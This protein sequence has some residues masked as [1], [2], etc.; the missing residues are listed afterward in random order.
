MT[1]DNSGNLDKQALQKSFD[2]A[3]NHEGRLSYVEATVKGLEK[4]MN[5]L[6]S[7]MKEAASTFR[8]EIEGVREDFA[9]FRTELAEFRA[10]LAESRPWWHT[11][12]FVGVIIASNVVTGVTI[13]L[14]AKFGVK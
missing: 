11:L 13:F 6:G 9:E 10:E 4:S 14:M 12:K 7:N 1:Q 8:E 5:D 2:V 3:R